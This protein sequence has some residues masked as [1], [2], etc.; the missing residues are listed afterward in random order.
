MLCRAL[1]NSKLN[2]ADLYGYYRSNIGGMQSGYRIVC[3]DMTSHH[4]SLT[5]SRPHYLL[6]HYCEK[7]VTSVEVS[8]DSRDQDWLYKYI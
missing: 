4:S 3:V 6:V 2:N 1:S 7:A 8:V 5:T